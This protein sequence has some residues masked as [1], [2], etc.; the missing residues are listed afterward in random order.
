MQECGGNFYGPGES[1]FYGPLN[2]N[3]TEVTY[4]GCFFLASFFNML[5]RTVADAKWVLD[6]L[7]LL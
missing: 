3:R 4:P 7:I 2:E 5:E 6:L 1:S